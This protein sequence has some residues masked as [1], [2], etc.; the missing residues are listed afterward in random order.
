MIPRFGDGRDW[1]FENRFGLFVHWGLY[2][3]PAWHEQIQWRGG[4]PK[5]DYV[6]FADE[7]NPK[8]FK[9][10]EWVRLAKSAGMT[11][12]CFT[13]KHHD[14]FCMWDTKETD[15]RV[16]KTPYKKDILAELA[17]ACHRHGLKLSL[18]YSCP[19]WHYRHARN[20][21]GDHELLKQNPGDE[22]DE[23]KY[24]AYVKAQITE[25]ATNYGKISGFFWDIPPT[26]KD[27]SLNALLRKL[28]PGIIINDR[29]YDKGDFA[30]PEREV[31]AGKEFTKPTEA[32]QSVGQQ[33]WGH[34]IGE[35]YH[36]HK[37]LMASVDK[38][39]A[40]GGNYLLNVGPK[41]DGTLPVESVDAVKKV[42]EWFGKVREALEA[43]PAS[44]FFESDDFVATRRE[45]VL[46]I[47]FHKDP[48]ATGLVVSPIDRL[49]KSVTVMN[50]G[51]KISFKVEVVPTRWKS[52]P[53]LHLQGIPVNE[54]T[55]EPI[56]LKLE[57]DSLGVS[58]LEMMAKTPAEKEF[59]Y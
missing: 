51:K 24:V 54:I 1:F 21:G 3:I 58:D 59:I 13:T 44:R 52:R 55:S 41:A 7:F 46:Y 49:P 28:Q 22:P 27:P 16:T 35:D 47:H 9:P 15:Y 38:I 19:D 48:Q 25:L 40:M 11:Y 32:C 8:K 12:L 43:E 37:L 42:G 50:T 18:Y 57:F 56:V 45:N 31:P 2:A 20:Q 23:E 34:R 5:A 6:K 30:T 53:F 10:D 29:G 17:A 33:S 39:L 14:G 26:R 36:S 4:I